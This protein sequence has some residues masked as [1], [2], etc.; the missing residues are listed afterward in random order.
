M[1]EAL[2]SDINTRQHIQLTRLGQV[3]DSII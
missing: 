2:L 3:L 1:N